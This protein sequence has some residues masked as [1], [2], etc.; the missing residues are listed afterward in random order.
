MFSVLDVTLSSL[1]SLEF[2]SKCH[3]NATKCHFIYS[4]FYASIYMLS[5][6]NYQL[7]IYKS[8]N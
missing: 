1:F 8:T 6:T 4:F 2:R 7:T 5:V 3:S